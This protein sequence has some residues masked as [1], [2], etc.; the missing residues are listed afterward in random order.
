MPWLPPF[1]R[2]YRSRAMGSR[3]LRWLAYFTL[4]GVLV[5]WSYIS[6]PAR[7]DLGDGGINESFHRLVGNQP[8]RDSILFIDTAGT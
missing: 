3:A 6:H 7:M 2:R 5:T 8:A 4:V 1:L